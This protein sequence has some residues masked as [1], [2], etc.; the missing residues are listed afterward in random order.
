VGNLNVDMIMGPLPQWPQHGTECLLPDY[1]LRVGGSAGNAALAFHGL[2]MN[3][4]LIT[5]VGDDLFADW[6]DEGMPMAKAIRREATATTVSVGISHP[7]GERTF[8]TNPGHIGALAPDFVS[9]TLAA[10]LEPG[11]AVLFCGAFLTILLADSY[12]EVF[13]LIRGKGGTVAVDTGWPPAGWD[14]RTRADVERWAGIVDH[15]FLSEA[16]IIGL[17]EAAGIDEA[18]AQTLPSLRPGATLVAKLGPAGAAAWRGSETASWS[19]PQ[20]DVV[21][22]IGAGDVFNA[23]YLTSML[24]GANLAEAVRAGVETASI[25]ISTRPRRYQLRAQETRA[26][27]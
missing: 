12:E 17:S 9:T 13:A 24:R 27:R 25:A 18:A 10:I 8:L 5:N 11:A 22:T 3:P 14:A 20:V 15:L 26:V 16:E 21:D 23:A 1:Q 19:A 7:N 6:L 4:F 2:G